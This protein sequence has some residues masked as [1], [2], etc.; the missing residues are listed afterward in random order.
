M[1][2]ICVWHDWLLLAVE[3]LQL[4][5]HTSAIETGSLAL[6]LQLVPPFLEW[7][8]EEETGTSTLETHF[9][10]CYMAAATSGQQ[11]IMEDVVA[12]TIHAEWLQF[13]IP[14]HLSLALFLLFFCF[15]HLWIGDHNG[16]AL[17]LLLLLFLLAFAPFLLSLPWSE[18]LSHLLLVE[19]VHCFLTGGF[20]LQLG[21]RFFLFG[22]GASLVN[23]SLTGVSL[24]EVFW[25]GI[26][27]INGST[28]TGP[29]MQQLSHL[30][31]LSCSLGCCVSCL[32]VSMAVV[33][34]LA[35]WGNQETPWEPQIS[36]WSVMTQC[37]TS[38]PLMALCLVFFCRIL[39]CTMSGITSP[40]SDSIVGSGFPPSTPGASFECNCF[41]RMATLCWAT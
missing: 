8:D 40:S 21:I 12:F 5:A 11:H 34:E 30:T 19:L 2:A 27:C 14:F 28:G 16:I 23:I 4:V 38:L 22:I 1:E 37:P 31:A 13:P 33:E 32:L 9:Q 24:V 6:F 20:V 3:W 41:S 10:I 26:C 29:V 7:L 25:L 36:M 35:V 39:S 17:G 15:F 18:S